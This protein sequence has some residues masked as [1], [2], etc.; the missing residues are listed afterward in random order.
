VDEI[1]AQLQVRQLW[2]SQPLPVNL[3]PLN[4]SMATEQCHAG[5]SWRWDGVHFE[6]LHP[7]PGYNGNDNNLSCVLRVTAASGQVTLLAGDI[8]REVEARLAP[9]L[10]PVD[11][12]LAPHH[13]S[14]SSSSAVFVDALQPDY[15]VYTVGYNNRFGFPKAEVVSRYA[16]ID[17]VQLSTANGGATTFAV[18]AGDIRVGR[19]RAD[20]PRIWRRVPDDVSDMTA[21]LKAGM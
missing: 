11:I 21:T 10:E 6:F 18:G 9:T 7:L 5:Q 13:G 1:T 3:Q 12:L 2:H 15:V 17:A 4:S 16:V 14:S 19:Y 8:E 20:N